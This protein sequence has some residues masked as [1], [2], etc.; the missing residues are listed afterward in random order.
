VLAA[1]V[2]HVSGISAAAFGVKAFSRSRF[3]RIDSPHYFSLVFFTNFK[4]HLTMASLDDNVDD[5]V[6][7][8]DNE[9]N[10][11]VK[12]AKTEVKKGSYAGIHSSGFKVS[13]PTS[14]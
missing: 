2:S 10:V 12:D 8:D 1:P 3:R 13:T 6:D 9:D 4:E 7:Y 11:E 14:S 5:L